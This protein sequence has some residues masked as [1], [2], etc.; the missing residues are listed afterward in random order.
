[1]AETQSGFS[2]EEEA[3]F[4]KVSRR[5]IWFL[6]LLGVAYVEVCTVPYGPVTHSYYEVVR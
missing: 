5:M 1:M 4:R 3:A 6:L 2:A